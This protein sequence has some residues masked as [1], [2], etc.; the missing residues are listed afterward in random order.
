MPGHPAG[1]LTFDHRNECPLRSAEDSRH[2]ADRAIG[3]VFKREATVTER[4]LLAAAGVDV[5]AD[6]AAHITWLTSGICHRRFVSRQ[7]P[8]TT[9]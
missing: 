1:W 5:P 2:L 4:A 6:L 3:R 8:P 9:P 7:R